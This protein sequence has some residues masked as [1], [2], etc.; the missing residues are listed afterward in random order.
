MCGCVYV[1]IPSIVSAHMYIIHLKPTSYIYQ[2]MDVG[3]GSGNF[4]FLCLNKF[5]VYKSRDWGLL[6]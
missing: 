1:Y 3:G 5:L 2:A 4:F 6:G